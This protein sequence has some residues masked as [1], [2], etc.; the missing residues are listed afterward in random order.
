MPAAVSSLSQMPLLT[1]VFPETI[2]QQE[3]SEEG[4]CGATRETQHDTPVGCTID[5]RKLP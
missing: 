3:A 5:P 2:N 4:L 1:D